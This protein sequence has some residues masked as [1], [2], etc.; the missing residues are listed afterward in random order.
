VIIAISAKYRQAMLQ[1]EAQTVVRQATDK[2]P[3]KATNQ[4]QT[5][6]NKHKQAQN[7]HK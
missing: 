6:T 5:S 2:L 4:R 7:K 1:T 3:D